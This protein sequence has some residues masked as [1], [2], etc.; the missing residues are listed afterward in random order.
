MELAW[1]GWGSLR[2]G[3][4]SGRRPR[5]GAGGAARRLRRPR[6]TRTR[7]LRH[8]WRLWERGAYDDAAWGSSCGGAV[9]VLHR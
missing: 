4:V 3:G 9:V 5:A 8:A 7:H 6:A 1:M 2:W